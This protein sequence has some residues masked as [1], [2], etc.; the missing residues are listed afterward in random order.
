MDKERK[1]DPDEMEL[2]ELH[3]KNPLSA[4]TKSKKILWA[5]LHYFET[6]K[7]LAKQLHLI[8]QTLTYRI[9]HAKIIHLED[10]VKMLRLLKSKKTA[11]EKW[12]DFLAMLLISERLKLARE[13][14]AERRKPLGRKP[15]DTS[16]KQLI[17]E[18]VG[19]DF[20]KLNKENDRL[21][22][23]VAKEYGFGNYKTLRQGFFVLDSGCA[24]V[25]EAMDKK[26]IKIHPAFK[27]SRLPKKL[28]QKLVRQGTLAI[29]HYFH[30]PQPKQPEVKKMI[31]TFNRLKKIENHP[32]LHQAEIDSQLPLRKTVMGLGMQ[33]NPE[34]QF[35]WEIAQLQKHF[36]LTGTPLEKTLAVLCQYQWIEKKWIGKQIVGQILL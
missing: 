19:E 29:Q 13:A 8:R 31:P 33:C 34:G 30:R 11:T 23:E 36:L 27:L 21:D 14:L 16:K 7:A 9:N 25:I 10:G 1:L 32:G 35:P 26:T 22:N 28:Q 15:K 6:Q 18:K 3:I 17:C 12:Q 2:I 20:H 4:Q 5:L 24:E